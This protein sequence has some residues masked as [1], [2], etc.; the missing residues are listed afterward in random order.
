M[1]DND[2]YGIGLSFIK[3]ACL[4]PLPGYISDQY[5]DD[6]EKWYEEAY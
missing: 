3:A 4:R 6:R 5:I 1:K 2:L